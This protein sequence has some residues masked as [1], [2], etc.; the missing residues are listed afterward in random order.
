VRGLGAYLQH[1]L[2]VMP[3]EIA[4]ETVSLRTY[5]TQELQPPRL[6]PVDNDGRGTSIQGGRADGQAAGMHAGGPNRAK[7][8]RIA[9]LARLVYFCSALLLVY[10]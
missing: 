4:A 10:E 7:I 1:G 3:G 9:I 8:A 6:W 2:G 5:P